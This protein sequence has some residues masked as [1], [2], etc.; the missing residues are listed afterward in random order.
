MVFKY[1]ANCKKNLKNNNFE[2]K[3]QN[4]FRSCI[5]H[6]INNNRY[7]HTLL[8]IIWKEYIFYFKLHNRKIFY[9]F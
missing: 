6:S 2:R 8:N 9:F 5:P 7:C 3:K 4:R 1:K